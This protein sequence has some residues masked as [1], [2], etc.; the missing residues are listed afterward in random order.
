MP[1]T[2]LNDGCRRGCWIYGAVA[3]LLAAVLIA[4]LSELS[5]LAALFLG[6]LV[7]ALFGGFLVWGFCEGRGAHWEAARPLPPPAAPAAAPVRAAAPAA[8]APAPAPAAT[9]AP[10]APA[11]ARPAAAPAAAALVSE[12]PA[13][14]AAPAPGAAKPAAR[15]KAAAKPKA[16]PAKAKAE[17]AKAK[18]APKPKRKAGEP[19]LLGAPRGGKADDLKLIKGVGPK[20]EKLLND[21]GIWHFEQIASWGAKDIAAIDARLTGFHGRIAREDWVAQA[22]L[23]ARGGV[24]EHSRRVAGGTT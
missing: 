16:A 12:A 14:P 21:T 4:V 9:P 11:P 7:F 1:N 5:L 6:L 23:L 18:A 8:P 13:A 15:P 20:L 24:T 22:R 17:P 19:E 10:A 2:D 3:G